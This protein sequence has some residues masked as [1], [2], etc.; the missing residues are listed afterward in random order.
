MHHLG[1]LDLAGLQILVVLDGVVTGWVMEVRWALVLLESGVLLAHALLLVEGVVEVDVG[2]DAVV[3]HAVVGWRGLEI[4]QVRETGSV[5]VA[6][7][8]HHV[9]VAVVDGVGL[10]TLEEAEHVVL[11]DGVLVDGTSVG[12]SGLSA[13]AVT[14][15][16]DILEPVVLKGVAVD[17]NLT[18]LVADA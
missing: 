16:E 3:G 18:L 6:E 5:S 8:E 10:L 17:I 11:D 1:I 2:E 9:L 12:T 7:P 4:V 15:G 13:D 14:N